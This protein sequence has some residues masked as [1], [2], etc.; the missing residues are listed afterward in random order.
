MR[1]RGRAARGRRTRRRTPR[2][3][4]A[5]TAR[6]RRAGGRR[7]GR[8]TSPPSAR[9]ERGRGRRRARPRPRRAAPAIACRP[10]L[11][12]PHWCALWPSSHASVC[13]TSW[14]GHAACAERDDH[15]GRQRAA[16]PREPFVVERHGRQRAA[17]IQV[18]WNPPMSTAR[19]V[20][21]SRRR[22]AR[23]TASSGVPSAISWT[24]GRSTAPHDGHERGA[25]MA[26][27]P[28]LAEPVAARGAGSAPGARASRGSARASGGGA[29]RARTAAAAWWSA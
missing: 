20:V 8:T 11:H 23:S 26:Q 1:G 18:P 12:G 9:C 7:R 14:T 10:L 24:P 17:G 22:R 13:A 16:V 19:S 2:A 6:R 21:R 5:G 25:R 3:R 27:R 15:A 4:C 28:D 29:G